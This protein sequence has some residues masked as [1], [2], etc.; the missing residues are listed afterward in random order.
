MSK[1]MMMKPEI[2]IPLIVGLMMVVYA[3]VTWDRSGDAKVEVGLEQ[4]CDNKAV[5]KKLS[6]QVASIL[7]GQEELNGR[8]TGIQMEQFPKLEASCR[9]ADN[10]NFKYTEELDK[11][12]SQ[13]KSNSDILTIR[14]QTLD[15]KISGLDRTVH[16]KHEFEN[17]L[18]LDVDVEYQPKPK[19]K[20]A[21][22]KDLL[23]QSG[24]KK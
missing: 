4:V 17:K 9:Q 8:I 11:K 15:K 18:D 10:V 12:L 16:V 14:Q 23:K 21:T 5:L 3:V 22:P 13:L 2:L 7:K 6:D 20:I 19:L 24:I 1:G